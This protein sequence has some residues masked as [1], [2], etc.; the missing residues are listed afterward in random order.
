MEIRFGYTDALASFEST[1]RERYSLP[2]GLTKQWF[3]D[4]LTQYEMEIAPTGYNPVLDEFPPTFKREGIVTI[5][6]LMKL[7]YCERE[8]SRVNK[9]NNIIGKDVSL[10]GTGETKRMTKEELLYEQERVA[11]FLKKQKKKCFS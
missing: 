2:D 1:F 9:L 6:L 5:G 4:S 10:N 3:L 8:L 11:D 7:R